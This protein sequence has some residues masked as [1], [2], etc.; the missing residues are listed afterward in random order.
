MGTAWVNTGRMRY[1]R[2]SCEGHHK[3]RPYAML[4]YSGVDNIESRNTENADDQLE[5]YPWSQHAA[6]LRLCRQ[7]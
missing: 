3:N 1:K 4:G 5:I 7:S 2:T 6:G